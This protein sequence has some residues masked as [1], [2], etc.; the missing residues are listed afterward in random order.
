MIPMMKIY[1]C[2]LYNVFFVV[3]AVEYI[4]CSLFN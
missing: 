1:D 3:A 2:L 4:Y